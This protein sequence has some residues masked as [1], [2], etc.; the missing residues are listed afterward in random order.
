MIT[1]QELRA[2]E[3]Y[4]I[5]KPCPNHLDHIIQQGK[6]GNWCGV[7]TSFGWCDGGWPSEQWLLNY[8]KETHAN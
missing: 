5:G 6:Y 3:K 8:R 4:Q 2:W 1:E 7:K